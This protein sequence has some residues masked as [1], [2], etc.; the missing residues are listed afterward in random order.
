MRA[1]IEGP[2]VRRGGLLSP[3]F[4]ILMDMGGGWLGLLLLVVPACNEDSFI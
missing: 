1:I 4:G 2:N 3:I